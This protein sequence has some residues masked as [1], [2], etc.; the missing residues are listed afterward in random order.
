MKK[1][2]GVIVLICLFLMLVSFVSAEINQTKVD[3]AYECLESKVEG[4]C[5]TKEI[6]EI[7]LTLLSNPSSNTITE[8]KESLISKKS[9]EACWPVDRCTVK[10]TASAVIALNYLGEDTS[11]AE[12][13]LLN[14]TMVSDDLIW[15]LEQDSNE[16]T[17]CSISYNGNDFQINVGENKKIDTDAGS[18]LIKT[19][20]DY[21]LKVERSCYEEEFM[22]SCDKAFISTLLYKNDES[23]SSTL[24]VLSDTQ[25]APADGTI[26]LKINT[27]CFGSIGCDYESSTW[28][29]MALQ[30]TAHDISDFVP[31]LLATASLNEEYLPNALIYLITDYEDYG[32]KLI[33]DQRGGKYWEA[34]DSAYERYYDTGLALL[35]LSDSSAEQVSKAEDWLFFSQGDNGCWKK[36]NEIIDTAMILWAI[37]G[38]RKKPSTGTSGTAVTDCESSDYYCTSRSECPDEDELDNYFCYG[39]SINKVCC[40]SSSLETCSKQGGEFCDSD[41]KCVGNSEKA[42]DGDDCCFGKCKEDKEEPDI[43]ECEDMD[44]VC[45]D[46]CSENQEDIDYSCPG[47]DYCCKTKREVDPESKANWWIWTLIIGIIA[48]ILIII[49]IKRDKLKLMMFKRKTGFKSEGGPKSPFSPFPPKPGFPP[50]R[51]MPSR[52]TPRHAPRR[53]KSMDDT[54]R[55]LKDMTK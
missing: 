30:I 20:S 22:I 27:K 49:Y 38:G 23:P 48:F 29:T 5:N 26:P 16:A 19:Q 40:K 33:L 25:S 2:V 24:F 28:A 51:R 50:I 6:Q 32:N 52:S 3:E 55:K 11:D 35:A 17:T 54:F 46:E 43:P 21:W 13:W 10:E 44:Y 7:A 31:Y 39:Y 9:E 47:G 45:K 37:G 18:C 41:E 42:S 1:K 14:Q 12:S 4:K 34:T 53:N 8:C 15:Y 36:K